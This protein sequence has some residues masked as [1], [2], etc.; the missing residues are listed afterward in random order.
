[1]LPAPD[2]SL[3]LDAIDEAFLRHRPLDGGSIVALS[4]RVSL[5]AVEGL[6]GGAHVSDAL[7][8]ELFE[9]TFD[10]LAAHLV[11]AGTARQPSWSALPNVLLKL[12]PPGAS[13]EQVRPDALVMAF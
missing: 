8:N 4:L 10:L 12:C 3:E 2:P 9:R 11:V 5:T 6:S 13:S 1:M 7:A